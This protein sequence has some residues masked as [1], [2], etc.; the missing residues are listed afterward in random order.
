MGDSHQA[1]TPQ[2]P[3]PRGASSSFPLTLEVLVLVTKVAL[4]SCLLCMELIRHSLLT[5]EMF[6]LLRKELIRHSI[7]MLE[8]V[9][10]VTL[11]TMEA[12]VIN[13]IYRHLLPVYL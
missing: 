6:C 8:T 13:T 10:S 2:P 11:T 4:C 3:F 1:S 9:M 7:L 12:L 5:L